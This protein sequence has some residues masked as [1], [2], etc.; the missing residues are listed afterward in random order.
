MRILRDNAEL[1]KVDCF[2]CGLIL[3]SKSEIALHL[4]KHMRERLSARGRDESL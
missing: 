4:T 1:G 3:Q 2:F